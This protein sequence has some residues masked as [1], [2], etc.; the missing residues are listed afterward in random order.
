MFIITHIII[1]SVLL[2]AA[3]L[4]V[5]GNVNLL[6][7]EKDATPGIKYII[8]AIGYCFSQIVFW[9]SYALLGNVFSAFYSSIVVFIAMDLFFIWRLFKLSENKITAFFSYLPNRSDIKILAVLV[10][11]LIISSWQYLIIGENN[12]YHSGNEDFFDNILGGVAYLTSSYNQISID[13]ISDFRLTYSSQAF[14]RILLNIN[15]VDAF[16][17]QSILNIMLTSLGVYWLVLLVFKGSR[18]IALLSSF[19]CVTA[20]FYLTTFLNGHIG[21]M[22]YGSVAPVFIGLSILYIRRELKL[23]WIILVLLIFVF[24]HYTYPGPIYFLLIPAL[25]LAVH[26]RLFVPY[27]LYHKVLH[28]LNLSTNLSYSELL[29]KI[30]L[31]KFILLS[32]ILSLVVVAFTVWVYSYF[33]PRRIQ[34]LLR[35][36]V[37]W[38]ISLFKEMFMIF[39]GIYPSGST[40]TLSALP[41]FISNEI[42]NTGSF[43]VA[44]IISALAFF[45]G[46]K[47]RLEKNK[48]YLFLYTLMFIPFFIMM[49]YFWGSPYYFYK[50]LYVNYFIIVIILFMWIENSSKQLR[51]VP[52]KKTLIIFLFIWG[53]LNILWD[54]AIGIDYYTRPY[55]NKEK[56]ADFFSRTDK[57]QLSLSSLDIPNWI[58]NMVFTY[59]FHEKG[60]K[61]QS[62]KEKAKYLIQLNNYS[63]VFH[64]SI[65]KREMIYENGLLMLIKKPSENTESIVTL[66]EPEFFGNVNINW[67]GNYLSIK[68]SIIKYSL[69]ELVNYLSKNSVN[70][71]YYFDIVDKDIYTLLRQELKNRNI[72]LIY[73]INDET[74]FVQL[75]TDESFFKVQSGGKIV[76]ENEFFRLRTFPKGTRLEVKELKEKFDFSGLV[77]NLKSNHNSVYLDFPKT[78]PIRLYLTQYLTSKNIYIENDA[79]KTE[80]VCR[81]YF[82]SPMFDNNYITVSSPEEKLLWRSSYFNLFKRDWEVE[83][84]RITQKSRI[85]L[86]KRNDYDLPMPVFLKHATGDFELSLS[87]ISDNAKYLRLL[88]SPGPS[89]NNASFFIHIYGIDNTINIKKEISFPKTLIDIPISSEARLKKE[90]TLTLETEGLIGKSLLPIDDRYLNYQIQAFEL[91]NEIDSYSDYI[92]KALNNLVPSKFYRLYGIFNLVENNSDIIENVSRSKILFGMGWYP[93]EKYNNETFRWVSDQPAELI[94]DKKKFRQKEIVFDLAPGPGNSNKPIPVD[95]IAG[96]RLIKSDT[97]MQRKKIRLEIKSLFKENASEFLLLKLIPHTS[98]IKFQGDPRILNF[99]VFNISSN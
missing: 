86:S 54:V 18:K 37:S 34:A 63:N 58:Q 92:I 30:K 47:C 32:I 81:Y 26:E 94:I 57:H 87:N 16:L 21:S 10:S 11:I 52:I 28:F 90:M 13:Y 1:A 19:W 62:S 66:Y 72:K 69:V 79:T 46:I 14:W 73:S 5:V 51:K 7:Y 88:I 56:I 43:I 71:S 61:L 85:V 82:D 48:Q 23:K 44:L 96:N 97:L 40:G 91:T 49:R 9:L 17:I 77:K 4:G 80:L 67:V 75:K 27:G 6:T 22:M 59:I 65:S 74:V 35:I 93:L 89:F 8:P 95:F 70:S 99:R 55:N 29:K 20:N 31:T 33:E 42:I 53:S 25:I 3:G 84:M 38:K 39:W 83:L 2:Y 68:N 41:L 76:W 36:N 12:Y 60:I 78:D 45:A 15:G 50:F 24:A 64:N 98:N